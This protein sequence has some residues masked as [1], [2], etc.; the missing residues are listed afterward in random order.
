MDGA[1]LELKTIINECQEELEG[2]FL[3]G[4]TNFWTDSYYKQQFGALVIGAFVIDLQA[5]KY[6]LEEGIGAGMDFL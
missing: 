3:S 1:M 4:T 2:I 5:E 6:V